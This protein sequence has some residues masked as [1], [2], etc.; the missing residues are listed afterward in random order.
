MDILSAIGNT[1]L[2]ELK[3]ISVNP[4]VK[5]YGK[6]EGNNPGGSVKDRPAYY[7]IKKAEESGELTKGK[8]ILEPT[9]GNTGIAVAMISAAKGYRVKLVMPGCVSVERSK[10]LEAF[11]AEVVLTPAEEGTDGAIR[12]AHQIVSAEP[13]MYY[14]PNQFVN[15]NNALAH[16]ETTGPEIYTQTD[17][18][19]DVFVAGMGTTGTLMGTGR[20]LKEKKPGVRII[21]AEPVKGHTIQ[22]LKNMEEAIVPQIYHPE[23]LDEKITIKDEE[24]FE[25]A[26]MLATREGIFAGMSSGASVACALKVAERMESGVIVAIL[27][28][29]GD[30]YLSTSLF[31]SICAKC[32][33]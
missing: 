32:S 23:L 33:P 28:D 4:K 16:Y 2:V 27:S 26:R 5:I 10:T 7:M 6:L 8:I 3:N 21:G 1:P 11:G 9:S 24:A 18:K 19:V 15:E 13:D 22:G 25:I 12:L 17:G 20:Y 30:R 31:M 14:M 29:R